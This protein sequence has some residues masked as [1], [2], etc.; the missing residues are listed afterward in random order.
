[1]TDLDAV[2]LLMK[3]AVAFRN[4]SII[5]YPQSPIFL[6][7][8]WAEDNLHSVMYA[9][10]NMGSYRLA[11]DVG[12]AR[13][14]NAVSVQVNTRVPTPAGVRPVILYHSVWTGLGM[15]ELAV[16]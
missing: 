1:M 6:P 3:Q 12:Q 4:N 11:Q 9:A 15:D 5:G 7:D 8:S 10:A 14:V 13:E 2:D 16:V